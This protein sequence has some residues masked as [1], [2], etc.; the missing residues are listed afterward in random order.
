[1]TEAQNL[2]PKTKETPAQAIASIVLAV[3]LALVFRSVIT[4]PYKIPSGSMIPTLKV[5]DFIFVSKLSYGLKVP[6]TNKNLIEFKG[7][8]AGDVIVFVEPENNKLDFIKRVVA[9]PGDKLEVKS[10]VLFINDQAVQRINSQLKPDRD[11]FRIQQL[12]STARIFDETFE[13][14]KAHTVMETSAQ[15]QDFGPFTVPERKYFVMGDNRDNSRDSRVWGY[16]PREN[17]RGRA[18]YIWLSFDKVNPFVTLG[19]FKIPSI[20]FHRFGDK[21]I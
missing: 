3:V 21:I 7:P 15:V 17:I 12:Y 4:S 8:K 6:F 1:M 5:G 16:L 18:T 10:D 19:K 20:R 2:K 9:L 13:G 11:D 14:G